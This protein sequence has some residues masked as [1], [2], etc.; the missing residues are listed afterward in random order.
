MSIIYRNA[1]C[2][3]SASLGNTDIMGLFR[4]QN[5]DKDAVEFRLLDVQGKTRRVRASKQQAR[6]T[7]MFEKGP[8]QQRGRCFQECERSLRVLHFIPTQILFECR[9]LKAS[10]SLPSTPVRLQGDQACMLDLIST[11][12]IP[13]IHGQWH[14]AVAAYT[15]RHL[16]EYT[17]TFPALSGL[18]KVVHHSL[19]EG[20][21]DEEYSA[22]IWS[23][24]LRR[25]L[26]WHT[27]NTQ[28][29]QPARYP[30]Y[31]APT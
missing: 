23:S 30:T 29:H 26:T 4:H 5:T 8:L 22:G 2:T 18:A 6:W 21:G 3:I 7:T 20:K 15:A 9:C 19:D 14:H 31:I 17:D 11:L 28:R 25:S 1:Y 27:T 12:S 13:D 10:Q 24:N 16:T